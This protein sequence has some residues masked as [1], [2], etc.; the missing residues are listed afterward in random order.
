MFSDLRQ[1]PVQPGH[2]HIVNP[3]DAV[4]HD[5]R[6]HRRLLRHRQIAGAGADDAD[7]SRAL[8]Q[9]FFFDGDATGEF[10]VNGP[11]EFFAQRAGMCAGDARDEHARFGRQD[12]RGDFDDLFRRLAGAENDLGKTFPERAVGVHLGKAEV[13]HGRRLE[14]LQDLVAADSAGA[15][16]F[17]QLNRF[18]NGHVK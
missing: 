1:Q 10:V 15:E 11:L 18:G 16:L 2:A 6:R 7:G 9:R 12:F 8:G 3:L 17:Q 5:F 14:G 13:G 4:A